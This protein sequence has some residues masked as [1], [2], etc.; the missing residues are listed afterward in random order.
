MMKCRIEHFDG[1]KGFALGKPDQIGVLVE[2]LDHTLNEVVPQDTARRWLRYRY[3]KTFMTE[4]NYRCTPSDSSFDVAFDDGPVQMEFIQHM[5]G[6]N[7]YSEWIS[8]QGYGVHHLGWRVRD[9]TEV[10][11]KMQHFGCSPVQD[12]RG[13]GLEGDGAFVY[14]ECAAIPFLLEFI[15]LPRVRKPGLKVLPSLVAPEA[16]N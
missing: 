16:T 12:G 1:I 13:Y 8:E 14:Y 7:I 3:D 4:F 6:E 11:R 9:L 2:N 15:E 5:S 10:R